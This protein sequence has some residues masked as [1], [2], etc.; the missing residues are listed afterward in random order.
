MPS[1]TSRRSTSNLAEGVRGHIGPSPL[2]YTRYVARSEGVGKLKTLGNIASLLG[3]ISIE[4]GGIDF[5]YSYLG[6]EPLLTT[7][8][9][10]NNRTLLTIS[11]ALLDTGANRYIFVSKKFASRLRKTLYLKELTG[12]EP[13]AVSGHDRKGT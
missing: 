2:Y 10:A 6:G 11:A 9:I 13:A 1:D 4:S 8:K 5:L 12:F 3:V 7:I